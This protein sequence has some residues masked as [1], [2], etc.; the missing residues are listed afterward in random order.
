MLDSCSVTD[1]DIDEFLGTRSSLFLIGPSHQQQVIAPLMAGL[2]DSIVQR[3][4][5]LAVRRGGRLD[6]SLLLGLD[7]VANVGP[8]AQPAVAGERGR[9]PRHRDDM[10]GAEPGADDRPP[11]R[12]PRGP[13][14]RR[15]L[16][17]GRR[18]VR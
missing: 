11:V 12:R 7:E 1:L 15:E 10:G 2:V 6:P 4:A 8:A 14:P 5:E 3:A 18:A 9:R 16:R 17:P 13:R